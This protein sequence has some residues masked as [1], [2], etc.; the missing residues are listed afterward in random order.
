MHIR[1]I[2]K[3]AK[4]L[5][6]VRDQKRLRGLH[7]A[8]QWKRIISKC[9]YWWSDINLVTDEFLKGEL[10]KHRGWCR[11]SIL[12]SFPKIK[13]WVDTKRLLD[14]LASTG[15]TKWRVKEDPPGSGR[16]FVKRKNVSLERL[17]ALEKQQQDEEID[18]PDDDED[19][20]NKREEGRGL[21]IN[22]AGSAVEKRPKNEWK[23][24]PKYSSRRKVT[25]IKDTQM[26]ASFSEELEESVHSSKM[27]WCGDDD[28]AVVGLDV[29]YATLEFDIAQNL[30]AMMQL[31]SP[32]PDGPVGLIWLHYMPSHGKDILFEDD[33]K[34]LLRLLESSEIGKVGVSVHADAANLASWWGISDPDYVGHQFGR[35]I[36]LEHEHHDERVANKSLAEMCS[37]VLQ[38][39]LPKRKVGKLDDP[40]KSHWRAN[41]LTEAMK[42][43]AAHDAASTIDIWMAL[44]GFQDD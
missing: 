14:A 42:V 10:R 15:A 8:A 12:L 17:D 23:S 33:C 25:V 30:P 1:T 35:L 4:Y 22:V 26:I 21:S 16:Y 5:N 24:L 13:H 19:D 38:K 41:E 28:A 37:S 6:E 11:V 44:K 40:K 3:K 29:E 27:K 2:S 20:D 31:A 18:W 32:L 36:S 34:P 39:D 43:Y 9:D 7:P